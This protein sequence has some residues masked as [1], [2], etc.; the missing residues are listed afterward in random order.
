MTFLIK[1]KKSNSQICIPLTLSQHKVLEEYNLTVYK[2]YTLK[3][4]LRPKLSCGFS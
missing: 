3:A 4:H 2:D 1:I